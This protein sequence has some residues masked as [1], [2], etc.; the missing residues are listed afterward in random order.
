[1][2]TKEVVNFFFIFFIQKNGP[3]EKAVTIIK[4]LEFRTILGE[5]S[6]GP[7]AIKLFIVAIAFI[8]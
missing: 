5:N 1:V 6:A 7:S 3:Y 8:R 2:T 4:G